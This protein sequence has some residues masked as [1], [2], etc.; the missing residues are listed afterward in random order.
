M[1]VAAPLELGMK[2]DELSQLAWLEQSVESRVRAFFISS[3]A[4]LSA[5]NARRV[6]TASVRIET[7][8][9]DT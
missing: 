2:L 1:L 5:A 4:K 9:N 8:P 3:N 7:S 6:E